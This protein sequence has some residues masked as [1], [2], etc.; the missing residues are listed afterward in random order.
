VLNKDHT[1]WLD[2]A[3]HCP[4]HKNIRIKIAESFIDII[5]FATKQCTDGKILNSFVPGFVL[6][7]KNFRVRLGA[8]S[9]RG[10]I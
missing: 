5:Q 6:L 7:Q 8:F 1:V 9:L 3:R 10:A 4:R 2:G